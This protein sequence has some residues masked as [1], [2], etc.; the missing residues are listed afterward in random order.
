MSYGPDQHLSSADLHRLLDGLITDPEIVRHAEE[1]GGCHR[2]LSS[3]SAQRKALAGAAG[4]PPADE[5]PWQRAARHEAR[6]TLGNLL[7]EMGTACVMR[8][9]AEARRTEL[10]R[11]PRAVEHI[12]AEMRSLH[13]RMHGTGQ[14]L[15]VDVE[16][17]VAE[18][19]RAAPDDGR[20]ARGCLDRLAALEGH[21]PR[22]TELTA[23]M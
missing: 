4:D 10:A 3:M 22:V 18:A 5:A 19:G 23:R 11:L 1:C 12:G 14:Q 2:R 6:T 7:H 16:E 21:T 13:V 17:L 20:L 9:N 8:L 15:P